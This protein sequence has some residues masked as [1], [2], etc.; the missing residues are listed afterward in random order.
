[1]PRARAF[2]YKIEQMLTSALASKIEEQ[3]ERTL[4]LIDCV[5]EDQLQWTPPIPGAWPL[6]ALLGHL[7]DCLA[8]F[9]AV[10]HAAHPE[11]LG[12]FA[13]LRRLP[14]NHLCGPHEARERI[15]VYRRHIAEGLTLSSDAQLSRKLPTVFVPDGEPLL[16]LL[17]GNLEHLINHK[18]QL[19]MY[20]KL[21][22]V[23]L[24]SADL[25]RFRGNIE[26]L[27]SS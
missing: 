20:L 19:F 14:V 27:P 26:E 18:H 12:H 5:P 6:A 2:S 15:A 24:G 3:I 13:D 25:Y 23:P 22:G 21:M 7:L 9:C 17:L 11:R 4:H 1:M 10:L 8:G 16:T